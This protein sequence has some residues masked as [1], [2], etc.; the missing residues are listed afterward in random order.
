MAY[1]PGY[2]GVSVDK[3]HVFWKLWDLSRFHPSPVG[4]KHLYIVLIKMYKLD[5]SLRCCELICSEK[6]SNLNS[7]ESMRTHES[8]L[9]EL[10]IMFD[11]KWA[12]FFD[13]YCSGSI[14]KYQPRHPARHVPTRHIEKDSH[15]LKPT[16]ISKRP[17]CLQNDDLLLEHDGWRKNKTSPPLKGGGVQKCTVSSDRY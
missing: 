3:V 1:S 13:V 15:H 6:T 8:V 2:P 14:V 4:G 7:K 9:M 12:S 10:K 5:M 16:Q 11:R 17:R